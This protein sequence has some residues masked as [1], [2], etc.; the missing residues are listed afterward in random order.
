MAEKIHTQKYLLKWFHRRR[1]KYKG[2]ANVVWILITLDFVYLFYSYVDGIL[3]KT[4][5]TFEYP[6]QNGQLK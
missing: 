5:L 3:D 6:Y 1:R 4:N 2:N